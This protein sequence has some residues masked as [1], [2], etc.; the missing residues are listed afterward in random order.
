MNKKQ[1]LSQKGKKQAAYAL[2]IC[3]SAVIAITG[4]YTWN[5]YKEKTSKELELAKHEKELEQKLQKV[6]KNYKNQQNFGNKQAKNVKITKITSQKYIS[7]IMNL[8]KKLKDFEVAID[9]SGGASEKLAQR[10]FEKLGARVHVIGRS[11]DF[12]FS[13]LVTH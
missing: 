3:F 1:R 10:V 13:I 7:H 6:D 8:S 2:A 12:N 9:V 11:K 5:S 4:A